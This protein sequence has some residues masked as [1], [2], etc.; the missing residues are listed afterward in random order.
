MAS[1]LTVDGIVVL[2]RCV[3]ENDKYISILGL[4]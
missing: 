1:M 3:G 4:I 2:E